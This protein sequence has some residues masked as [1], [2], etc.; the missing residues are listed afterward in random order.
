[1]LIVL[2]LLPFFENL[3]NTFPLNWFHKT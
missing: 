1:M 2:L 3:L